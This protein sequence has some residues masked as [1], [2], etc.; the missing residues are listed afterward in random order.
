MAAMPQGIQHS[1]TMKEQR[2]N[3]ILQQRSDTFKQWEQQNPVLMLGEKGY[4]TD[5][6]RFKIGD[7]VRAWSQLPYLFTADANSIR[8]TIDG[9]ELSAGYAILRRVERDN[10]VD[11]LLLFATWDAGEINELYDFVGFYADSLSNESIYIYDT[12]GISSNNSTPLSEL[13][14]RILKRATFENP[15]ISL[16]DTA[17]VLFLAGNF[18]PELYPTVSDLE[19]S[20]APYW[21][22][23]EMPTLDNYPANQWNT[24]SE[25]E[26]H[27]GDIYDRVLRS[28]LQTKLGSYNNSQLPITVKHVPEGICIIIKNEGTYASNPSIFDV[29]PVQQAEA[30]G[31]ST[32]FIIQEFNRLRANS[33]EFW[34]RCKYGTTER[35]YDDLKFGQ[36]YF[37]WAACVSNGT[38]LGTP[39]YLAFTTVPATCFERYIFS[40]NSSGAYEWRSLTSRDIINTNN[41]VDNLPAS[42]YPFT[43]EASTIDGNAHR[44]EVDLRI[45]RA[46]MIIDDVV[47]IFLMR[48]LKFRKAKGRY[49]RHHE[50]RA[51]W[52]HPYYANGFKP[53]EY[54]EWKLT[55]AQA[56]GQE[57]LTLDMTPIVRQFMNEGNELFNRT[58]KLLSGDKGNKRR[59]GLGFAVYTQNASGRFQRMSDIVPV[60][61]VINQSK[62]NSDEI[63]VTSVFAD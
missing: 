7:G 50:Q 47:Y 61:V 43:L 36:E 49:V 62:S 48:N 44:S 31:S 17:K 12:L 56:S 60:K 42:I 24:N 13:L 6:G 45:T 4:E 26:E 29:V 55:D 21:N 32:T 14:A 3:A 63:V 35:V 57:S 2:I 52:R 40:K 23:T 27:L 53:M 22:G 8:V 5:T 16:S 51:G 34:S 59:P 58:F 10:G 11:Y 28:D 37:V 25:R 19:K 54:V 39:S 41:K 20:R 18:D 30:A 33:G 15:N 1:S 46:P 9:K 38:I